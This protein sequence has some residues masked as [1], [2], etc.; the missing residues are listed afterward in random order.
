MDKKTNA[1]SLEGSWK[2]DW[3]R[4]LAVLS[5]IFLC[6]AA[7]VYAQGQTISGTVVDSSG[8]AI[9]GASISVKGTT[10]G[11]I[12]DIGGN[13][14]ISARPNA[15]IVITYLGFISQEVIATPGKKIHIVLQE[16]SKMLDEVVVVG[17]GS[18]RKKDL[19]GS[20]IQIKPDKIASEAPKAIA[21]VLRGTPGLKV[22][23]STSAKGGGSLEI[24]GTRSVSSTSTSNPL[25][26]LDGMP[27]YGELSEINPQDIGQ[28]DILKDASSAAVFGSRAANG[29]III[30]TKKGK[31]GKPVVSFRANFGFDTKGDFREVF[32]PDEYMHYREDWYKSSSYGVNPETGRYE[33]YQ[34]LDSKGN[35]VTP[36]GYYEHP[37]RLPSGLPIETWRSTGAKTPTADE[38]DLSLYARR[39]DL[40]DVILANYLAGRSFDWYN[41]AFRT[42]FNQDYTASVSGANDRMNYYMSLGYSSNESAIRGDDYRAVR[43]NLK[44]SGKVTN[45]LEISANVNFQDRTDQDDAIDVEST[46]NNSPYANY[47]DENG[48]LAVHPMGGKTPT[49]K[50]YNYDFNK[51]YRERERGYTIFNN[52]L[53]AKITLPYNITYSFNASPRYQFYYNRYF[54]SSQHPDRLPATSG[55]DRAQSKKFEWSINNTINWEYTFADKHHLNLTL[56]QEAEEFRS[57]HDAI[58]ARNILPSDA[59]GFHNTSNGGKLESSFSST[60]THQ[61]ATGLLGRLFYSYDNRYMFTGSLRR[62]GYSAF[63]QNDPYATFPS[64]AVSWNFTNEKFFKWSPMSTG[65]LRL[66]W[67][68]NGNRSLADPYIS[69]SNLRNG[70]S[71]YG[72]LDSAGNF[73]ELQ[74]LLVERLGSPNLKW[75]KSVALNAGL[76]FGF[77]ND[78]ITGT[79]ELYQIDTEDMILSKKLP[80]FTGFASI[81]TNLGKVRNSGFELTVSSQ[82]IK[83]D[84]FEWNTTFNFAYNKNEIKNLYFEYEDV[85]DDDGNVI[86]SK[87]RDEYGTWFIG[88]NINTI[89][90]YRVTGI[91][92][93]DEVEE[94]ARYG[95]K[96]GDPKVANNYTKDDKVNADGTV[97]PVYNDKDKEFLGQTTSPYHWS[98]RNSFTICKNFDFSF[99]IYSYFGSK[100][101]DT[102][103]LNAD[104]GANVLTYGANRSKKEY[105]TPENPSNKYAR[106]GAKG[107]T[108]AESPGILRDR[109]FIRLENIS[110]GY[111]I[112]KSVLAKWNIQNAKIYGTIRNVAMW[113][114]D[115][116]EYGDVETK[117][118][119]NRVYTIGLNLTF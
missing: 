46:L 81:A 47:R 40:D 54:T 82:N 28:I 109:S 15:T 30:T 51:Q 95:Q 117:G 70:T 110:L 1:F 77:F 53:T 118:F 79:L 76:D 94:A 116:Y 58:N 61:S 38:S 39:L 52:I 5:V 111:N 7:H 112:P 64:F 100:Y 67:G 17:Y 18:M 44:L 35:R 108:G 107:P 55:T 86:G 93:A 11:S 33:A 31:V 50:G 60:D 90:N 41:H 119:V 12:S 80:G 13:F 10:N 75:E 21:D 57:W 68:K 66:S 92:Q 14:S 62:D 113:E 19:T 85:L 3:L 89:W 6:L 29:V 72:Y 115:K 73:T 8:E 20:V 56:V 49:F 97:T 63:A 9:I 114:K 2:T 25:I 59:L 78:R 16:D 23:L 84:K 106:L 32:S 105:W 102:N 37:D 98:M 83:N 91:W 74:Y 87:E 26:I 34:A 101:L 24:R 96:P 69:L 45:W 43:A 103:Y 104:N 27:F 4:K 71:M 48:E 99:N 36:M 88:R 65:K 22:G 42:G